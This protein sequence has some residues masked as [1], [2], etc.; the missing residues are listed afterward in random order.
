VSK[1][2]LL[3]LLYVSVVSLSYSS[4]EYVLGPGDKI[5]IK[6]FGHE[7]L[8]VETILSDNGSINYPFLGDIKLSSLTTKEVSDV[9]YSGLLGD[10]LIQPNVYVHITEYRKFYIHGEVK[11]PGGYPFQIGLTVHQAIAISGGMTERASMEKIY[12]LKENDKIKKLGIDMT[13]S[14]FAGDTI[15]VDKRFF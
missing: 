13:G 10:Y 9:V 3:V 11:R 1:I 6:V 4:D 2:V 15:I 12:I 14:I 7:E 8:S 5:E